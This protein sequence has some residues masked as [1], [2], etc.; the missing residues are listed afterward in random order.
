V[1]DDAPVERTENE[2]AAAWDAI[3]SRVMAAAS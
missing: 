2:K 1:D 3:A